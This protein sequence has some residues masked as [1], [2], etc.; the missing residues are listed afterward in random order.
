MG[1]KGTNV[2]EY[3]TVNQAAGIAGINRRTIGRLIARGTLTTFQ[4]E[5]DQRQV[6]LRR[7]DVEA[8]R[9]ARP[10]LSQAQRALAPV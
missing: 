2:D 6:L 3:V 5:A 10:R 9:M 8:L 1:R 7:S 4:I